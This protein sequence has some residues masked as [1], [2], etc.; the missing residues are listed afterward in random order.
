MISRCG[1]VRHRH[2]PYL[3]QSQL[4][5]TNPPKPLHSGT[6]A[7]HLLTGLQFTKYILSRRHQGT[8]RKK[9]QERAHN[10]CA[11]VH[12]GRTGS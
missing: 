6:R 10:L 2:A 11:H 1:R 5:A 12:A 4:S 3:T 8:Q 9:Q 7:L